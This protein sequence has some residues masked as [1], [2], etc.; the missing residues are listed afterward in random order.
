MLDTLMAL[1]VDKGT[2]AAFAL[3]P[4]VEVAW[5][6]GKVDDKERAG[7]AWL[8]PPSTGSR[9]GASRTP[10]LEEFLVR[11]RRARM[12]ARPGTPGSAT[13]NQHAQRGGT[14]EGPRG[15]S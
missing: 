15:A 6:D 2:F 14:Q 7:A 1:N 3:Y 8:P 5:A 4:L 13:L 11:T 10:T 9:R 12:R